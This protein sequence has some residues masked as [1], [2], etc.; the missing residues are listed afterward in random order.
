VADE[1]SR[2]P[3]IPAEEYLLRAIVRPEWWNVA[4]NRLSSGVLSHSKF[5]AFVES[6]IPPE[7]PLR[8]LPN[9]SPP[10]PDGAGILRFNSGEAR[11]HDFDARHE[12]ENDDDA[13]ANVYCDLNSNQRKKRIRE[14]LECA[15][16]T[17]A[18]RP[19]VERLRAST[20]RG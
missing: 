4:E 20:K 11:R 6:L 5:S 12:P 2:G 18:V 8:S 19:V 7:H 10:F 16:T 14:L 13:H 1:S 9:G 17:V 3:E 15:T